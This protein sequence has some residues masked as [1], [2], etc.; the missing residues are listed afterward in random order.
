M[1]VHGSEGLPD[2]PHV[3]LLVLSSW[4]EGGSGG[5][6]EG[7]R[8]KRREGGREG[9]RNGGREWGREEGG[10]EEGEG[11]VRREIEGRQTEGGERRNKEEK[12]S[13]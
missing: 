13:D 11:I 9:G 5:G 10:R 8:E 12:S 2:V 3:Y 6:R 4:R 1:G 7:G